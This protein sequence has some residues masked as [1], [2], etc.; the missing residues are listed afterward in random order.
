MLKTCRQR[1]WTLLAKHITS[2]SHFIEFPSR[3]TAWLPP[4]FLIWREES[5]EV[6][7]RERARTGLS[8]I[9]PKRTISS[10][11]T[12]SFLKNQALFPTFKACGSWGNSFNLP[13]LMDE[14]ILENWTSMCGPALVMMSRCVVR[15]RPF[16]TSSITAAHCLPPVWTSFSG[17]N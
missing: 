1:P 2:S 16:E 14:Y 4:V 6:T 5:T 3:Y 10:Q 7:L 12:K 17:G 9:R 13:F 11:N 15:L 8:S